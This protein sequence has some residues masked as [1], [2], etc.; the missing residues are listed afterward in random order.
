MRTLIQPLSSWK[1]IEL[2]PGMGMGA[3]NIRSYTKKMGMGIGNAIFL[4]YHIELSED[5][6]IATA[7]HCNKK[8]EYFRW[9]F[10]GSYH[11]GNLCFHKGIWKQNLKLLHAL[12][13]LLQCCTVAFPTGQLFALLSLF[14]LCKCVGFFP[15]R[16]KNGYNLSHR[17]S[18][19]G[20][21]WNF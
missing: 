11:K 21:M 8:A 12:M 18:A 19:I 9:P 15:N 13:W 7:S 10:W 1:F 16:S 17:L 20:I 2:W 4:L 6:L 3:K 14:K 5:F